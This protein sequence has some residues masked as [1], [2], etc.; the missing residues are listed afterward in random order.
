ML[1]NLQEYHRPTELGEAL[2]L[3]NRPEVRTLPLGGG[4][5]LVGSARGDVEAVVDLSALGLD[6]LQVRDG[7]LQVGAMVRLQRL[8]EE[9]PDIF[10]GL[11]GETAHRMAGW[12]I[13]NAATVGGTLAG[14]RLHSP[15]SVALCALGAQ[16][17]VTGHDQPF[18]WP[19]LPAGALAGQLITGVALALPE[20]G[21]GAAY[22]QV[23]RTPAD[24]PIVCAAAVALR[25]D[26]GQVST[27]T[28]VGGLEA[29]A[30]TMLDLALTLPRVDLGP[31]DA[32]IAAPADEALAND[33]LGSGPY[34]R[35]VAGVLA[36][37]ALGH[38]LRRLGVEQTDEVNDA[39]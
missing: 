17:S 12:N 9:L 7:M 2:R 26:E 3:L 37:R 27:R 29:E 36:R 39:D 14:G 25:V 30:L 4:T 20:D 38:A 28:V 31:L 6:R 23:A 16:V 33:Y 1:Y 35:A 10:D 34:R 19:D 21:L 8:V 22:E 5:D 13:R 24:Q 15:L 32:A 18:L 11:L